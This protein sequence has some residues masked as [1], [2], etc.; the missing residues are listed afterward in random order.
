[1]SI[2]FAFPQTQD[3][4]ELESLQSVLQ[5][6]QPNKS[7]LFIPDK[8]FLCA[9][10]VAGVWY[11]A[12]VERSYPN[13]TAKIRLIDFGRDVV[14]TW[15][16]LSVLERCLARFPPFAI[17][18]K[19]PNYNTNVDIPTQK[20]QQICV[21]ST[22][23]RVVFDAYDEDGFWTVTLLVGT[24]A[25]DLVCIDRPLLGLVEGNGING[26]ASSTGAETVDADG[27][28]G[29]LVLDDKEDQ[30]QPSPE[31]SPQKAKATLSHTEKPLHSRRIFVKMI[32]FV[33]PDE[34]YV[35]LKK[36]LN[37][38]QT[39]HR[40][41]QKICWELNN[42]NLVERNKWRVKDGCYLEAELPGRITQ[43]YRGSILQ[44]TEDHFKVFL[45]DVGA[46][47]EADGNRIYP[48]DPDIEVYRSSVIQ[49][50]LACIK[51]SD[52][53]W[54]PK[55]KDTIDAL[56]K[57]FKELAA[58]IQ[59]KG[60]SKPMPVVLWG[61]TRHCNALAPDYIDWI[62][63]NERLYSE[64]L[65]VLDDEFIPVADDQEEQSEFTENL[66][67]TLQLDSPK[68]GSAAEIDDEWYCD[69]TEP[70]KYVISEEVAKVK[71]WL[72]SE[73]ISKG[74]FNCI[75]MYVD[76]NCRIYVLDDYRRWISRQMRNAIHIRMAKVGDEPIYTAWQ[77]GEACLA[78]YHADEMYYR[79]EVLRVKKDNQCVVSYIRYSALLSPSFRGKPVD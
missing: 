18:C 40:N 47:V 36:H 20:F 32:H 49:C 56:V 23:C 5:I 55:F 15:P 50:R 52:S 69:I 39:M 46:T 64:G 21:E 63:L 75:P 57:E 9:G 45:M 67:A 28:A 14:V 76:R 70:K 27:A 2:T 62:N 60:D 16:Q 79:A 35:C 72:P 68:K 59:S 61:G 22:K 12:R 42:D 3:L 73:P 19:L 74:L 31:S 71:A 24:N 41:I 51:P 66:M 38:R 30:I 78:K 37:T 44:I 58:S 53:T 43:W 25:N 54:D 1:M 11:R 4:Q 8:D 65:A 77:K 48:I 7:K 33:S 6:I 13:E 26:R 34:F 17:K 29:P 10:C